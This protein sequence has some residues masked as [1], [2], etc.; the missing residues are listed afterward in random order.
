MQEERPVRLPYRDPTLHS[1]EAIKAI[2]VA[3][4]EEIRLFVKEKSRFGS[5]E[6][7]TCTQ[8]GFM[9]VCIALLISLL[10]KVGVISWAGMAGNKILISFA[11]T[12][13]SGAHAE[14]C[15]GDREKKRESLI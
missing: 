10:H 5:Q 9:H 3:S 8:G 6:V 4:A 1:N 13:G 2:G 14:S 15:Q 11:R 12:T 7:S